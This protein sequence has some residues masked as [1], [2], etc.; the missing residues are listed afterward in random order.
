MQEE[1]DSNLKDFLHENEQPI[2]VR[3]SYIHNMVESVTKMKY[4]T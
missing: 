2:K 3:E 4:K 1:N